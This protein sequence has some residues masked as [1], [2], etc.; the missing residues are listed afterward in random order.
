M[1]AQSQQQT[2]ALGL[3]ASQPVHTHNPMSF[4]QNMSY[5]HHATGLPQLEQFSNQGH[6]LNGHN[7]HSS[8]ES[9]TDFKGIKDKSFRVQLA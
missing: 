7:Q 6:N 5:S 3:F 2:S 1:Q 4:S 9:V 8:Q